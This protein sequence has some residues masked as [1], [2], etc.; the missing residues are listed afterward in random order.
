VQEKL[1]KPTV[2]FERNEPDSTGTPKAE[3]QGTE[4]LQSAEQPVEAKE[5][6]KA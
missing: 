6:Q 3:V 4:T 2:E 1:Q 5:K